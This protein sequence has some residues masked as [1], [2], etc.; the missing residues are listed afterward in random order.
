MAKSSSSTNC[1]GG[2]VGGLVAHLTGGSC[3]KTTTSGKGSSYTTTTTTGSGS[4]QT[5]T[6]CTGKGCKK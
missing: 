6:T 3:T 2:V 5:T 4:N 1:K